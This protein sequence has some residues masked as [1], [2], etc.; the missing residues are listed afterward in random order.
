MLVTAAEPLGSD[1]LPVQ[2][3]EF[4]TEL[5]VYI[6]SDVYFNSEVKRGVFLSAHTLGA[7]GFFH[8]DKGVQCNWYLCLITSFPYFLWCF[9]PPCSCSLE[10]GSVPAT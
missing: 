1:L 4:L 7:L 3:R 2:E 10:I 9:A 6:I 5:E 8:S